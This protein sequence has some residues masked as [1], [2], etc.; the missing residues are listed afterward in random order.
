M[1]DAI[2]N[3]TSLGIRVSFGFLDLSASYQPEEVLLAVRESKGVYATITFAAGTRNFVNYVLLNG[4]TYQDNPQGAGDRLLSGLATTQFINGPDSVTLKYTASQGEKANFT[5]VSITGDQLN[6]EAKMKGQ[7]LNSSKLASFSDS[8]ITVE[9]PSNGELDLII[10]AQ[11]NP[12]NGLFSI[13]TNS[14]QPVKN[15][16]VGVGGNSTGL[17]PGAKAGLGVGITALLLGLAGGGFWAYKH[18]MGV[19]PY[20][21]APA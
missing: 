1:V 11:D 14:N 8:V 12:V 5:L 7:S 16:T 9:P 21:A 10:T 13:A 15:C 18:F 17:S 2:K 3:A 6:M 19:S 20:G 4:L